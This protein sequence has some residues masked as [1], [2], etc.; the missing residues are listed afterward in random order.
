MGSRFSSYFVQDCRFQP[1]EGYVHNIPDGFS[2]TKIIPRLGLLFTTH[3]HK[4]RA[5]FGVISVMEGSP[6]GGG[7]LPHMG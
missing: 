4:K 3:N 6:G 7:V 5:D 2:G 1:M